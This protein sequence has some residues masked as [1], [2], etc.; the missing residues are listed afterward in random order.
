MNCQEAEPDFAFGDFDAKDVGSLCLKRNSVFDFHNKNMK[1]YSKELR[2]K[3]TFSPEGR[4]VY[5]FSK[6]KLL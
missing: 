5:N 2:L 3:T 4:V 1:K 6:S